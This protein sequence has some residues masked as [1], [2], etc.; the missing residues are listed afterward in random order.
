MKLF[1]CSFTNRPSVCRFIRVVVML[2][3]TSYCPVTDS[4]SE[5]SEESTAYIWY[6]HYSFIVD[7]ANNIQSVL[8][9]EYLRLCLLFGVET[10]GCVIQFHVSIQRATTDAKSGGCQCD[11]FVFSKCKSA[12]RLTSGD[13]AFIYFVTP[14]QENKH[15][16]IQIIPIVAVMAQQVLSQSG[17]PPL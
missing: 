3:D 8:I 11:I 9:V 16:R 1:S 5:F 2:E 6:S 14:I 13:T 12:R 10:F 15:L 17:C 7:W 4:F